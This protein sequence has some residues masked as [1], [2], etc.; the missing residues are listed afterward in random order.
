MDSFIDSPS[1]SFGH[2]VEEQTAS[3]ICGFGRP[4]WKPCPRNN[5]SNPDYS[6]RRGKNPLQD[7]HLDSFVAIEEFIDVEVSE[8]MPMLPR[9]G[10]IEISIP[11]AKCASTRYSSIG[12]RCCVC[13]RDLR[14]IYGDHLVQMT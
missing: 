8:A 2:S 4:L 12:N 14:Q 7:D 10:C 6:S 13:H 3:A 9:N 11:S 5:E 1:R